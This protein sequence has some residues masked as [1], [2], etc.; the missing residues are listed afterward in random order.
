MRL[1]RPRRIR[2]S[3][4]QLRRLRRDAKPLDRLRCV[5]SPNGRGLQRPAL[6]AEDY[7]IIGRRPADI[8]TAVAPTA[9]RRFWGEWCRRTRMRHGFGDSYATSRQ[10]PRSKAAR[11]RL[12]AEAPRPTA[13]AKGARQGHDIVERRRRDG[14]SA[15]NQATPVVFDGSCTEIK[16]HGRVQQGRRRLPSDGA[17]AGASTSTSNGSK[18]PRMEHPSPRPPSCSR[19]RQDAYTALLWHDDAASTSDDSW[20]AHQ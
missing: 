7:A 4:T 18:A 6:S 11:S 5:G 12:E 20:E 1:R 2:R 17:G 16:S 14:R 13:E 9:I 19:R 10:P 3:K 8:A 15:S